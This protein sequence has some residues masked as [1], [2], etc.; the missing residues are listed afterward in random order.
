MDGGDFGEREIHRDE[1]PDGMGEGDVDEREMHRGE[2]PSG[3]GQEQEA[4]LV[5]EEDE[6]DIEMEDYG[7]DEE[8]Q[9]DL[10]VCSQ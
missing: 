3:V 10:S 6:E 8:G 2:A 4:G 9:G 7:D 5:D 1:P